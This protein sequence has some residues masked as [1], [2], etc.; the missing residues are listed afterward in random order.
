MRGRR[1]ARKATPAV[2]AARPPW[3]RNGIDY[4]PATAA[5]RELAVWAFDLAERDLEDWPIG[6]K[7][8][9][10]TRRYVLAQL[11]GRRAPRVSLADLM[12]TATLIA[13]IL[14][15]DLQLGLAD[16]LGVLETLELPTDDIVP[17]A[18]SRRAPSRTATAM[19]SDA[20]IVRFASPAPVA[21]ATV[22]FTPPRLRFCED[23][24]LVHEPGDHLGFGACRN[25]A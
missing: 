1:R 11:D 7:R 23:C 5:A 16:M 18:T 13:R 15:G 4:G 20:P 21:S 22:G 6:Q 14:D 8:V 2:A 12:F 25:A 10:N 24:C 19:N 17:L 9:H 3:V